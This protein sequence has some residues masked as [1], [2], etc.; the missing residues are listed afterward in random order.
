M[1]YANPLPAKLSRYVDNPEDVRGGLWTS[2]YDGAKVGVGPRV[3]SIVSDL[4]SW[5]EETSLTP[6]HY[7]VLHELMDSGF[8]IPSD[9][10]E[11][12]RYFPIER[13]LRKSNPLFGARWATITQEFNE[14]CCVVFGVP[15]D[16]GSTTSGAANGPKLLRQASK[17]HAWRSGSFEDAFTIEGA[18]HPALS[19][20][21]HDLGDLT[22]PR[23]NVDDYLLSVEQIV[24]SIS[25]NAIPLM[26]GGDHCFTYA[27]IQA[28]SST[29]S[30]P[31]HL[32]QFDH[33]LDVDFYGPFS[34][35]GPRNLKPLN[36]SNFISHIKA[37][38]PDIKIT[39]IGV[40]HYQCAE[41]GSSAQMLRH[42]D[43]IGQQFSNLQLL[44]L[45]N[46]EIIAEI[47]EA[48]D[49]YI[50][51]DVDVIDGSQMSS[52]GNPAYFGVDYGRMLSIVRD[53]AR[54]RNV[55]GLDIMEFGVPDQFMSLGVRR[56]ADKIALLMAEAISGI[57][58]YRLNRVG[59]IQSKFNLHGVANGGLAP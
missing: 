3:K 25:H 29:R 27:V 26:L 52:T 32:V 53:L 30:E 17:R 48:A 40:D 44:S 43:E 19:I 38:N 6:V 11:T 12:E 21:L 41:A 54:S 35:S 59:L 36:H 16:L 46:E 22:L 57:G 39:Q 20:K 55:I 51:F 9:V 1:K 34:E 8:L 58:H 42:L 56:E 50:S 24:K 10:E 47:D 49:V 15:R 45:K 14:D 13:Q 5:N 33:H 37:A 2:R 18:N 4:L 28:L 31:I 23:T 7:I